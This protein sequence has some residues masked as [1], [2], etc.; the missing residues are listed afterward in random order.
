MASPLRTGFP[1]Q[2]GSL[3][4]RSNRRLPCL[5]PHSAWRWLHQ[6][7]AAEG[8]ATH[9]MSSQAA[10]IQAGSITF[11]SCFW[12]DGPMPR[13]AARLASR[14]APAGSAAASARPSASTPLAVTLMP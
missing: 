8:R 5:L 11:A 10:I 7:T 2:L 1:G 14:L 3:P 13:T 6:H 4:S 12:K 9:L